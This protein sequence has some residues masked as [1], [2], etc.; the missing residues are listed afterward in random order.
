MEEIITDSLS[1]ISTILTKDFI[2]CDEEFYA[3]VKN[4]QTLVKQN[5]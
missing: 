5:L 3:V 4:T 1:Y 2:I